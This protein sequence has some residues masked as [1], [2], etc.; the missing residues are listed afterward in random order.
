VLD[1][2]RAGSVDDYEEFRDIA[3][4]T[5]ALQKRAILGSRPAKTLDSGDRMACQR[6]SQVV[7]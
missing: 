3:H 5:S 4:I 7:R 1:R 2:T 6:V